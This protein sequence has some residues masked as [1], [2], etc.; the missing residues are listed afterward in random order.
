MI[1]PTFEKSSNHFISEERSEGEDSISIFRRWHFMNSAVFHLTD[2][3]KRAAPRGM[4]GQSNR[5]Y[6]CRLAPRAVV[7]GRQNKVI[8]LRI[9]RLTSHRARGRACYKSPGNRQSGSMV[10]LRVSGFPHRIAAAV[11]GSRKFRRIDLVQPPR[12]GWW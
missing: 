5:R 1:L 8:C 4:D 11:P 7:P 2:S 6:W 10:P 3:R 12:R 9:R